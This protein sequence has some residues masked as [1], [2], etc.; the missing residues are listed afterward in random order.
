M[1][2]LL[3]RAGGG[4]PVLDA[5]TVLIIDEA[6][7]IGDRDLA[8]VL[9]LAEA[10][11]A[12]VRLIGDP[13]QH[14]SVPAGGSFAT[15]ASGTDTPQLTQVRRLLDPGEKERAELVRAGRV[16]QALDQLA[17]SGQL[18]LT[19]SEA[20][21]YAA[22]LTRWYD[23]RSGDGAH[24]MVH[25][26]NRERRLLNQLAQ[27]VLAGDGTIDVHDAVITADGRRLCVGDEVIARHGDR[28]VHPEGSPTAWMR[29]GTTG[30]IVVVHRGERP[31]DD[32]V[33]VHIA[34]GLLDCRRA[35]FDHRR[36]GLDLAY[37]V[38]SYA[39]QGSTR[40]AS[41][42]AVSP[43]TARSELYVD[44][45]RGRASNQLYATRRVGEETDTEPHLPRLD[46]ELLAGLRQRLARGQART[47]LAA[48]PDALAIVGLRHGR[49]LPGLLAARQRGEP[50]PVDAAIDR[51]MTGIRQLGRSDPPPGLGAVLPPRPRCPHLAA[52]WDGLAGDVAVHLVATPPPRGPRP[53]RTPLERAVGR[54]GAGSE[55]ERWDRLAE[56]LGRLAADITLWRLAQRG[57]VTIG[58]LVGQRP[59]WLTRYLE[60]L[61]RGGHLADLAEERLDRLNRIMTDIQDWRCHRGLPDEHQAT[62]LGPRPTELAERCRY[63]ELGRRPV[64]ADERA[65][66][67]VA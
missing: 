63:D 20:D 56:Q 53:A 4:Q 26:R 31:A 8:A 11:G 38:T 55:G 13:A 54:R 5:R 61:G 49:G 65:G 45:T 41:T 12:I 57:G 17:S 64:P 33:I 27:A 22:M 7:T 35:V 19:D 44:I 9:R 67:G 59:P 36:G 46:P 21:T 18:V 16:D 2:L 40:S 30:R 42:S 24:P 29:N 25:G 3:A 1:A 10:A 15:L 66:R 23:H 28:R 48:D 62:P 47:A 52:R 50:G 39:V 34:G 51:A 32:R 58:Q 43:T 14:G 37:A 60:Q 6:S